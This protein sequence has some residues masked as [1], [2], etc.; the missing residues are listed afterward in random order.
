MDSSEWK[1]WGCKQPKWHG[2]I[3][4]GCITNTSGCPSKTRCWVHQH[5]HSLC[6]PTKK[7]LSRLTKTC[8]NGW[9][10]TKVVNY[11]PRKG[12]CSVKLHRVPA[13]SITLRVV[14]TRFQDHIPAGKTWLSV[15]RSS[16]LHP[17]LFF[18]WLCIGDSLNGGCFSGF[19]GHPWTILNMAVSCC[20][21]KRRHTPLLTLWAALSRKKWW[22]SMMLSRGL[23]QNHT[24][25]G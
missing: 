10:L 2:A 11:P 8:S 13:S 20:V 17:T 23:R 15:P 24:S 14:R 1:T 21:Q 22:W 4:R 16:Y 9:W 18:A 12:Y 19:V 3:K 25:V 5:K 6:K 7:I